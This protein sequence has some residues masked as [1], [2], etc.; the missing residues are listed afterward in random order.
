MNPY[1]FLFETAV[2]LVLLAVCVVQI[3]A[4]KK[5]I[6]ELEIQAYYEYLDHLKK[7]AKLDNNIRAGLALFMVESDQA[8]A[9]K[10]KQLLF[11]FYA[12]NLSISSVIIVLSHFFILTDQEHVFLHLLFDISLLAITIALTSNQRS[13]RSLG[14]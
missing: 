9:D 4:I 1:E 6:D 2:L 12:R 7:R 5:R 10:K 14:P 11:M 3:K 8:I 13:V